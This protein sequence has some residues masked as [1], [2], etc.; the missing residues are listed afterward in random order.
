MERIEIDFEVFK[1]LTN[2]RK[3]EA[4]TYND[5]LRELL[6]LKPVVT[7]AKVIAFAKPFMSKRVTFPHGTEF[8]G[9]YKGQVHTAKVENGA[10]VVDNNGQRFSSLSDAAMSITHY[11]VNGWVFWECRRPGDTSWRRCKDLRQT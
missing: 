4:T 10:I 2:L 8:R 3:T 9:N 1:A 7:E 11:A 5:V 6:K